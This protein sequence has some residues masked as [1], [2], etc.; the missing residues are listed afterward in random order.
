MK[1]IL[2]LLSFVL[3]LATILFTVS[4]NSVP[5][6][7]NKKADIYI[8]FI[9]CNGKNHLYMHDS[10]NNSSVDSLLTITK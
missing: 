8:S 6:K 10:H 7:D 1:K 9:K 2:S 4:C 3:F 5:L